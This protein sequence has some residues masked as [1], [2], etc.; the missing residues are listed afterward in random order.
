[1]VLRIAQVAN[2][3]L[4]DDPRNHGRTEAVALRPLACGARS[5]RRA[6]VDAICTLDL[7]NSIFH[8]DCCRR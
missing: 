8:L 5:S 2:A 3:P 6:E 1:M 4:S 7:R